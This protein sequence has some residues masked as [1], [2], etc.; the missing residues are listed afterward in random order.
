M[1]LVLLSLISAVFPL[2]GQI[3]QSHPEFCGI[4]GGINP[5]L[6][7][8]VSGTVTEDRAVLHIRQGTTDA[9]VPL[10]L[11][12]LQSYVS[13]IAEVCPLANERLIVFGEGMW[14]T[15]VYMVDWAKAVQLDSFTAYNTV[16]SPD[17][18][19]I[20]YAKFYPA[21][22]EGSSEYMIYDLAKTPEQNRPAGVEPT[23]TENVGRVIFPPGH[24]NF[25]GSNTNLPEELRHVG[26]S[27]LYWAPDSRAILFEDRTPSDAGVVLVTID[28]K[29]KPS[30][31]R[32]SLSASEICGRET[33]AGSTQSWKLDR[34]D[35]GP[36]AA[37]S[38]AILLDLSTIGG[39]RCTPHVLQLRSEDFKTAKVEENVK[40][41][42]SRGAVLDGKKVIP[43]K[44]KK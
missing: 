38:R 40:P 34:V 39:D 26:A 23:D 43:P 4:P 42:Y 28:E 32:H 24:Q 35:I 14:A 18:R 9:V 12:T 36:G 27:R 29:G 17:Q 10:M 5:R 44:K 33:P 6:P 20:A 3:A 2:L 31:F 16:L 7:P 19:W 25:P 15:N 11:G 41:A 37:G 30:A 22:V 13:E 8:D 21:Q 1:K